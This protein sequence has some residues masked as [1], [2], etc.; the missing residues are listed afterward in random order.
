MNSEKRA[1]ASFHK[2][3]LGIEAISVWE[4]E[5][6]KRMVYA[7][8]LALLTLG[9]TMFTV[10]TRIAKADGIIGDVNGD[11]KVNIRDFYTMAKA[12]GSHGPPDPS[13][14]WN[15]ACD[16]VVDNVIDVK[17]FYLLCLHFGEGA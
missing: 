8:M 12:F 13:P 3:Y 11:G 16:I 6:P 10:N 7:I 1:R 15:P 5:M 2:S 14:N 9:L 17:D 4:K